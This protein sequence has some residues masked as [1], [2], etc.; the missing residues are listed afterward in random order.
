M[1]HEHKA[2]RKAARDATYVIGKIHPEHIA[3]LM[4]LS[5]KQPVRVVIMTAAE[6]HKYKKYRGW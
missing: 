2:K 1:G 3:A 5:N 6:W 4:E